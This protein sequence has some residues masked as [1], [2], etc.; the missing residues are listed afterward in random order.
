VVTSVQEHDQVHLSLNSTIVFNKV[1]L[2]LS[3]EHSQ[4]LD[5]LVDTHIDIDTVQ[6]IS[7]DDALRVE[8]VFFVNLESGL[9]LLFHDTRQ[10]LAISAVDKTISN[11]TGVLVVPESKELAGGLG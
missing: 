2:D 5:L 7:K 3:L 11:D 1:L 8:Q 9:D 10:V 4:V 6:E